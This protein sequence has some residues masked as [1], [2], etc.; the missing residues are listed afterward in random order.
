MNKPKQV[1]IKK[2]VVLKKGMIQPRHSEITMIDKATQ[3]ERKYFTNERDSME[4]RSHHKSI[5]ESEA[6]LR[7]L[8]LKSISPDKDIS[9]P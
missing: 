1:S 6:V 5:K 3:T 4:K 9:L 2:S 8:Q 7:I